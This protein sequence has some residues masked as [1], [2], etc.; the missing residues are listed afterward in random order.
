[1]DQLQSNQTKI[2]YAWVTRADVVMIQAITDAYEGIARIRTERHDG[3]RSLLMF[4]TQ[5]T[6]EEE[7]LDLLR[8]LQDELSTRIDLI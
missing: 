5:P 1:M 8:H 2:R 6:Q 3:D 4:M 7:L